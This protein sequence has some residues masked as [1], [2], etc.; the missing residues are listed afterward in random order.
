[1]QLWN[2][3]VEMNNKECLDQEDND[4]SESEEEILQD[5]KERERDV[6]R[7]RKLAEPKLSRKDEEEAFRKSNAVGRDDIR[8]FREVSR[9]QYSKKRDEKIL[10]E[11]RDKIEDEQYLFEGMKLTEAEIREQRHKQKIYELVKK[12]SEN[13]DGRV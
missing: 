7:T 6:V 4:K 8:T 12:K 9:R 3:S 13:T 2:S 10:E 5:Q 1:M 11:L